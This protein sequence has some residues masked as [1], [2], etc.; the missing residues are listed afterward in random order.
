MSMGTWPVYLT[1][2]A[3]GFSDFI[4]SVPRSSLGHARPRSYTCLGYYPGLGMM[5]NTVEGNQLM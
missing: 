5:S 4:S 1:S 3:L 2:I